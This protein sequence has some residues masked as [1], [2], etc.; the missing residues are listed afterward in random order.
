MRP[1]SCHLLLATML[2]AGRP[3]TGAPMAKAEAASSFE[4]QKIAEGVYAVIRTYPPGLMCDGNSVFIINDQDVVVVDAPEASRDFLAALRKL[5][6]KPVKY[7]INTHW[8]DDHIIGNQVY[9]DAF[10]GAEFIGHARMREYLPTTG[11]SNRKQMLDGA[12]KFVAQMRSLMDQGKSIAGGEL[13]PEE[14]LAFESDF[15]LVDRYMAEVPGAEIILP[16]ITIED[17]LTLHRGGRNIDVRHLGRGHTSGDLVVHLPQ[18]GILITGDL[19]VWPVPLVGSEQSHVRDWS[20]TLDKV[21]RLHPKLIVPGHGPVLRDDSYVTLMADLMAS[22]T[23]QTEAAIARGETLEQ[24]RKSV[25]I[26]EFQRR[27]AGDSKLLG[28][29]FRNYVTGPAVASAYG[30]QAPPGSTGAKP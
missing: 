21:R 20:A 22:V 11:L 14:R 24:A 28:F 16:T 23:A 1:S 29:L 18:E 2:L 25:N 17:S 19:V 8:H 15:K 7:V 4:V 30:S 13:T 10:P 26:E 5:T 27:F 12:P 3:G 6:K 9:R